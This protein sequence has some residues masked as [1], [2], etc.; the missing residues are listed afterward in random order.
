M[1]YRLQIIWF[2]T[3]QPWI[4]HSC[5]KNNHPRAR[6]RMR[7]CVHCLSKWALRAVIYAS[8][9]IYIISRGSCFLTHGV[10][11]IFYFYA[12][13]IR[14]IMAACV[15]RPFIIFHPL[16]ILFSPVTRLAGPACL[17]VFVK[18]SASVRTKNLFN[19]E[20]MYPVIWA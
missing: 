14:W 3:L 1:A 15:C 12:F 9:F 18:M 11:V 2:I 17:S 19:V 7:T 8:Y 5:D 10:S 4:R 6:L 16:A 20:I 13:S